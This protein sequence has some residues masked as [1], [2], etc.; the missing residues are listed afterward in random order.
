MSYVVEIEY[1]IYSNITA[2]KNF[3]VDN[4]TTISSVLEEVK[5]SQTTN[6]LNLVGLKLWRN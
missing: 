3:T 1:I 2:K 5:L 6:Y 4:K